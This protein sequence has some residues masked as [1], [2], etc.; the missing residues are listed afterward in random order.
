M[1]Q[2]KKNSKEKKD[3][4][5]F[6]KLEEINRKK[7]LIFLFIKLLIFYPYLHLYLYSLYF[8]IT[9]TYTHSNY[10]LKLG[11]DNAILNIFI[12]NLNNLLLLHFKISFRST[13]VVVNI[14]DSSKDLF[15]LLL[16]Q[17]NINRKI[18]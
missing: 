10:K 5:K 6:E 3:V 18:I 8:S 4:K 1:G 15:T 7:I 14:L 12:L 16:S 13:I 11:T 2:E 17:K 9:F